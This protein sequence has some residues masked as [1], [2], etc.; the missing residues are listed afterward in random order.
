M[1]S[2]LWLTCIRANPFQQCLQ[3]FW[4]VFSIPPRDHCRMHGNKFT[5][6][7]ESIRKKLLIT[8][9]DE[10]DTGKCE[11]LSSINPDLERF[12]PSFFKPFIPCF[13]FVDLRTSSTTM[14]GLLRNSIVELPSKALICIVCESYFIF[15]HPCPLHFSGKVT[16]KVPLFIYML[17]GH[18]NQNM[19]VWE[20]RW[21]LSD[22]ET[23]FP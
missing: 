6:W 4:Y 18:L 21:N 16:F 20:L 15:A 9:A 8:V 10:S 19:K 3:S 12:L 2:F 5:F 13:S 11:Y 22:N 7:R 14:Q 17:M 23:R 1:F